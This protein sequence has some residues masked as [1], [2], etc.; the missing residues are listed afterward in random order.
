MT[1]ANM[2]N[3]DLKIKILDSGLSQREVAKRVGIP[4][5]HFSMALHGRY[6]L[7]PEQQEKIAEILGCGVDEIF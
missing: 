4:E 3:R 2:Y 1:V 7:M 5:S 6:N